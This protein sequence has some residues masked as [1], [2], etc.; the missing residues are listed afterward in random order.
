MRN[1]G[2]RFFLFSLVSTAAITLACGSSP[3]RPIT[4]CP[5]IA[6][7]PNTTGTLQSISMCPAAADLQNFGDAVQFTPAGVYNTSPTLVTPLKTSG[8]GACKGSVPTS[9]VVVSSTGLAKCAVGA[10]GVYSVYTSVPTECTT[11]GPCG[12]GCQV[13]G[14]AQLTCP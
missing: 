3:L 5:D 6:T 12:T 7:P 1:A 9:D 11:V 8:W 13:S 4:A 2:P 14:Y 10:S